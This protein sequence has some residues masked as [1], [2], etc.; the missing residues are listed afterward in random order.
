MK[1]QG[2]TQWGNPQQLPPSLAGI[3]ETGPVRTQNKA[4][5]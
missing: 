1:E 3:L 5:L 4:D 2:K